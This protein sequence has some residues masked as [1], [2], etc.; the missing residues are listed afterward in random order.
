MF[1]YS[2]VNITDVERDCCVCLENLNNQPGVVAHNEGGTEHP[3]HANCIKEWLANHDHCPVCRGAVEKDSLLS[4]KDKIVREL[5]HITDDV[6][7]GIVTGADGVAAAAVSV[8]DTV[9]VDLKRASVLALAGSGLVGGAGIGV[10]A[11]LVVRV[12]AV[13]TILEVIKGGVSRRL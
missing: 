13:A 8:A 1:V 7:T 2:S 5:T 12:V 11:G 4:W 10:V 9:G 6:R 3:I